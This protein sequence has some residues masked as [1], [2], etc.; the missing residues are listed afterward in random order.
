MSRRMQTNSLRA[1]RYMHACTSGQIDGY[2]DEEGGKSEPW[3]I[4]D[5]GRDT[6]KLGSPLPSE[7]LASGFKLGVTTPLCVI[8]PLG[9][10]YLDQARFT[11]SPQPFP[12]TWYPSNPTGDLFKCFHPD[13]P[14]SKS[15]LDMGCGGSP[16]AAWLGVGHEALGG[17]N[18]HVSMSQLGLLGHPG[19]SLPGS[20]LSPWLWEAE[21]QQAFL[22]VLRRHNGPSWLSTE[23]RHSCLVGFSAFFSV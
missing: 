15:L 17:N 10:V 20:V 1:F 2:I 23:L 11:P 16:G 9:C 5:P 6:F 3:N 13:M 7:N 22:S 19:I 12:R 14:P 21:Q 4:P 8:L 18:K